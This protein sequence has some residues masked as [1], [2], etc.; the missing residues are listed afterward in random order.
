M[1]K[2]LQLQT[3]TLACSPSTPPGKLDALDGFL[4]TLGERLRANLGKLGYE[5]R[6][7]A[8]PSVDAELLVEVHTL[9]NGC[10]DQ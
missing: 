9:H 7:D 10:P 6:A 4:A 5:V 8:N 2:S 3:P 1:V